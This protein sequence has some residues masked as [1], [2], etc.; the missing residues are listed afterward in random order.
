MGKNIQKR[1]LIN[2][3]SCIIFCSVIIISSVFAVEVDI[4][5]IRNV[6]MFHLAVHD[7][8][9]EISQT[10]T[11]FNYTV[12]NIT[13]LLDDSSTRKL[14]YIVSL[15][16]HGYIAIST[17]TDVRPVIA[18]SFSEDFN[19]ED[20][21]Q[22]VCLHMLR[23]DMRNRLDAIKLTSPEIKTK[24]NLLW[25][26]HLKNE[27][28][29]LEI[30]ATTA[31]YGPWLD[32]RWGQGSFYASRCPI[33]PSTSRRSVAGCGPVAMGQIINY[34]EFPTSFSFPAYESY[35]SIYTDPHIWVDATTA[36]MSTIDYNGSG[37]HPTRATIGSLLFA[38]GV[39]LKAD[40]SS[41]ATASWCNAG[42]FKRYGYGT[43][44]SMEGSDPDFYLVLKDNMVN[45]MP[46]FLSVDGPSTAGHAI[47]CD[48][49]KDSGSYHLNMGWSGMSD[50]WYYLPTGMPSGFTVIR[51]AVLDIKPIGDPTHDP[52]LIHRVP[53]DYPT[54]QEALNVAFSG[55][56]VI[57]ADGRYFG[58]GNVDLS[59]KCKGIYLRSE[60]G[61]LACT[62]DC[63]R[64]N[65]AFRF[66]NGEERNS[67]IDGFTIYNGRRNDG[68]AIGCE[69]S[70]PTIKNN[71]FKYNSGQNGAIY[72]LRFSNARITNNEF[73][74]N[75]AYSSGT[76]FSYRSFATI[77]SNS[78]HNNT[79]NMGGAIN[80]HL[81]QLIIINNDI[82]ENTAAHS[83]AIYLYESTDSIA[84]NIIYNNSV[85]KRGGAISII[86]SQPKITLNE[87][88]GNRC[89][90]LGGAIYI[91][92]STPSIY[93]NSFIADTTLLG[94][95]IYCDSTEGN[96]S[97]N[98]IDS[99]NA[100][101]GGGF[102]CQHSNLS[103][104]DNTIDNNSAIFGGGIC[105]LEAGSR[106][107]ENT[108]EC[109]NA[110][111]GGGMYI[112]FS[113]PSLTGNKLI[114]NNSTQDGGGIYVDLSEFVIHGNEFIENAAENHGGGIYFV[115]SIMSISEN[116]IHNNTAIE[117]GGISTES[118]NGLIIEN[119][120]I[121]NEA[122]IGGGILVN[123]SAIN[124][125]GNTLYNNFA[126][127][128]GGI[129][130]RMSNTNIRTNIIKHN[131]ADSAGGGIEFMGCSD[132]EI[133]NNILAE[134]YTTS[135]FGGGVACFSTSL[136]VI[137]NN[138]VSNSAVNGCALYI[139][140]ASYPTMFNNIIWDNAL[141]IV[142]GEIYVTGGTAEPCTVVISHC[143]IDPSKCKVDPDGFIDWRS[144]II[145]EDPLFVDSM[146]HLDEDSPCRNKGTGSET[147]LDGSIIRAPSK[148]LEG[149]SRPKGPKFDIG[150]YEYESGDIM[151][152]AINFPKDYTLRSFPN[153]FNA[154]C[155]I[156]VPVGSECEII[157]INGR[158]VATY[159]SAETQSGEITWHPE[160]SISAGV[161]TVRAKIN[162]R[163]LTGR[164]LYVK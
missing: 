132:A 42:N 79:V 6:A 3:L 7:R 155:K 113:S 120:L 35:W 97:H 38:C 64:T 36:S 56:T 133:V 39:I 71:I 46:A 144:W 2:S 158:I 92:K 85:S 87:F 154:S 19:F 103:I 94:G 123:Q 4:E 163:T 21:P 57:V 138:I 83:G 88:R 16:P 67:V 41:H 111:L 50:A 14:V 12:K 68:A 118:S 24:N 129:S 107:R 86:E 77:D 1:T 81:S 162:D 134:N 91:F 52:P 153:P 146:F 34:W 73:T 20:F 51:Q 147:T 159:N 5:S 96:I 43:A 105:L 99:C 142:D 72:L 137:N 141:S 152:S 109:N 124:V 95:A 60:S 161:Y 45:S 10:D 98:T 114:R 108:L 69:S 115:N 66:D 160:K 122:Q 9:A 48:G 112:Y 128:G 136:R 55:D 148:D 102:F 140:Q 15:N 8:T 150:V 53:S 28:S 143:N 117:G 17:D 27:E 61:A 30:L 59:F 101:F 130:S 135:G 63:Q 26:Y 78:I 54:I 139:A 49:Y 104:I 125:I 47:V 116:D 74:E 18:Y 75:Q 31:T 93:S 23:A 126:D 13:P 11:D 62:I 76:I 100:N 110:R 80:S 149:E 127:Y 58:I 145:D 22:N 156:Y 65:R 164:I 89:D 90:S 119:S 131:R 29:F 33:D 84:G 40:Y 37:I 25:E 70:S 44:I 106:I 121:A 151:H 32:T 157:D 82:F